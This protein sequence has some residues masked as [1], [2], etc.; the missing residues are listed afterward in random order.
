MTNLGDLEIFARVVSTGS[1]SAAGRVLGFSPAVISKRIKRL[2]DRLGTRLLQRTTRQISLTEAGQG[3]YDR[4][5][6]I[7]SGI[8]EAEAYASGRS[9]HAL[10]VLRISAPTSFGRMHIAPHLTKFMKDHPDLKL[11]IVL[12]DEFTDIVADGFDMAVRIG[13]LVDSSLVARKLAPVRRL[14]CASPDYIARN[15]APKEIGDLANHLCLP[16]HNND[17]WKLEGPEGALVW[18]PEGPL[19]TNSSEIVRAA[20]IAGA[21]IALRSTWDIGPELRSG[22]LMQVLPQWEGSKQLTLSAVY[23]SRQFLPAKVR[24]FIDYLAGLY[25]PIPYWEQ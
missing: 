16:A 1:M 24:L 8:E 4:V 23:P 22:Q 12:T 10:G 21:G 2:E 7:L 19:V 18:H 11:H 15:G 5:L 25:G 14:L 17:N 20:V 3:F 13:E 6:G 9:S